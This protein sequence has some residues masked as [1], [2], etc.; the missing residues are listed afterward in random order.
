MSDV[1]KDLTACAE[2]LERVVHGCL[3]LETALIIRLLW[4]WF[5]NGEMTAN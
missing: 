3:R 2:F 4:Y 5:R 1:S